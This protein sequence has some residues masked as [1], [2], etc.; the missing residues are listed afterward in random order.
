MKVTVRGNAPHGLGPLRRNMRLLVVDF[1][2]ENH[3]RG[4]CLGKSI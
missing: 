1:E 4:L 3:S 2:L